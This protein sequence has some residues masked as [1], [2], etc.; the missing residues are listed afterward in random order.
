MIVG[1]FSV[2]S[3]RKIE[4]G[5]HPDSDL[6]EIRYTGLYCPRKKLV[7]VKKFYSQNFSKYASLKSDRGISSFVIIWI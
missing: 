7:K 2:R 1:T 3:P 5:H 6:S 4:K